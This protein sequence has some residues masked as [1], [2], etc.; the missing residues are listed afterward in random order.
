[1]IK[2]NGIIQNGIIDE[3]SLEKIQE[4]KNLSNLL[5]EYRSRI[6]EN[7]QKN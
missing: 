4:R 5:Y 6:I 7:Y 1:M 3:K 2:Q